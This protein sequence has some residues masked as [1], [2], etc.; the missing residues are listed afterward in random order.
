[1]A[2]SR[3]ATALTKTLVTILNKSITIIPTKTRSMEKMSTRKMLIAG[4]SSKKM[5]MMITIMSIE[6]SASLFR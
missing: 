4:K 5:K 6:D 3:Q 2:L 1:M